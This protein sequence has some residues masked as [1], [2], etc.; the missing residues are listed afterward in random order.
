MERIFGHA[1]ALA[2]EAEY[3]AKRTSDE[4]MSNIEP[5]YPPLVQMLIEA[6]ALSGNSAAKAGEI[7]AGGDR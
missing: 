6:A 5:K 4:A 3:A 7:R 2:A 1:A